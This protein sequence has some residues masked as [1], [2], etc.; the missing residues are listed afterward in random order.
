[1]LQLLGLIS[2]GFYLPWGVLVGLV[3]IVMGGRI[4]RQ[5]T[6]RLKVLGQQGARLADLDPVQSEARSGNVAEG[7]VL[8]RVSYGF[9]G[10]L[11][12][13]V[14]V[15]SYYWKQHSANEYSEYVNLIRPH[16]TSS[17]ASD[18]RFNQLI[19]DGVDQ[20]D[21][22][23]AGQ[24][25]A[26]IEDFRKAAIAMQAVQPSDQGIR[27]LHVQLNLY[28]QKKLAAYGTLMRTIEQVVDSADDSADYE[29][30]IAES[31]AALAEYYRL[32][33]IYLEKNG[34]TLEGS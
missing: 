20:D 2:L 5:G 3:L 30:L 14:L 27:P 19:L 15:A 4:Y 10:T 13:L 21:R 24:M 8:G 1:L 9:L 34:L 26:L 25:T 7:G 17:A 29:S 6:A 33:D 31:E 23:W 28:M 18:E 32:R 11:V 16:I 12:V 22:W